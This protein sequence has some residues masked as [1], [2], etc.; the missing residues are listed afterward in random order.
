MKAP[1]LSN[2]VAKALPKSNNKSSNMAAHPS[3]AGA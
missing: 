1:P 3:I 2:P